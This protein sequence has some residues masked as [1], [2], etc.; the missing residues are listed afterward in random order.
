M[1]SNN[2]SNFRLLP[3]NTDR[4][5]IPQSHDLSGIPSVHT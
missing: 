5:G 4:V 1:S 3:A 2:F